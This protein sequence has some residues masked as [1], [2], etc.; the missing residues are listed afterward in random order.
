MAGFG[1]KM[2]PRGSE[3][4]RR[5]SSAWLAV[6]PMLMGQGPPDPARKPATEG[7]ASRERVVEVYVREAEGYTFYSDAGRAAKLI[8]RREPVYYWSNPTRAGGQDG[9]VFVWTHRGRA[10][11]IG[12]IFSFPGKGKRTI[13]H[14]FLSLATTVLDVERTGPQSPSSVNWSPRVPGVQLRPIAEA[15][16]PGRTP[17]QRLTQMRDLA[18]DFSGTTQDREDHRWDLRLLPRPLYR[19]EST[20]PDVLDGAVFAF[21]TS[22]G[23]DPEAILVL[24]ARKDPAA[25]SPTWHYAV[26]RYTD[27]ALRMKLKAQEVLAVPFLSGSNPEDRYH[28]LNDRVIPPIED[29]ELPPRPDRP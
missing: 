29:G 23:T 13:D 15:A 20:D 10:E 2:G 1:K 11:V 4:V 14:E 17:A 26:G 16:A 5:R 21:G 12:T 27:M 7:Q 19:Y 8:L 25:T 18:R 22:A 24:E 9:G 3:A 6:L 28:V